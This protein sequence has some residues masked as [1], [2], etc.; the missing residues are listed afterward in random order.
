MIEFKNMFQ[1]H[2]KH[3]KSHKHYK[4]N[5][6]LYL[7][8]PI[9]EPDPNMKVKKFALPTQDKTNSSNIEMDNDPSHDW[10]HRKASI[11]NRSGGYLVTDLDKQKVL[12]FSD[13]KYDMTPDVD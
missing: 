3:Y 6:V 4:H 9:D 7:E 12:D 11:T 2:D 8:Q 1:K 10:N 5:T 13:A